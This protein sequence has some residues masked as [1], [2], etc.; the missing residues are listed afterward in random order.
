MDFDSKLAEQDF[1]YLDDNDEDS[2]V[3]DDYDEELLLRENKGET[4]Q[5]PQTAGSPNC[6]E[7]NDSSL[8]GDGLSGYAYSSDEP[9]DDEIS[10]HPDDSLFDEEDDP[11]TSNDRLR[12]RLV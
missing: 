2:N 10:L 5:D 1:K 11:N 9:E 3:G 4:Q 12:P 8:N 7:S 6:L